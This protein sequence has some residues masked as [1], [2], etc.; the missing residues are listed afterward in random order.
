MT[1]VTM[2]IHTHKPYAFNFNSTWVK[3]SYAGGLSES[4][5]HPNDDRY[6]N[7]YSEELPVNQTIR[8]FRGYYSHIDETSFLKAIGQQATDYY[9]YV[10]NYNSKYLGVGSYRRYLAVENGVGYTE[11]KINL[12]AKNESCE[13]LTSESQKNKL[14]QYMKSADVVCSRFRYMNKSIED[15]YLESQL[16]EY[17]ELFKE[18]IKK[19]C[20]EYEKH[21]IWFTDSSICNYECVYMMESFTFKKMVREYFNVMEYIWKNC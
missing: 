12:P 19:E 7:V 21:L 3:P 14:L 9:L 15:Q 10:N 11:E 18:G 17:W 13:A 5:W 6:V 8:R 2:L 1:D 20:P 4:E 16:P